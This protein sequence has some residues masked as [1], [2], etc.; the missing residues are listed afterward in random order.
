MSSQRAAFAKSGVDVREGTPIEVMQKSQEEAELDVIYAEISRDY[1]VSLTN[2]QA[3][4]YEMQGKSA[5]ND[6]I[7]SSISTILNTGSQAVSQYQLA[8]LYGK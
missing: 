1:N 6:S 2:T 4:I 3:G 5:V 8:K 7:T